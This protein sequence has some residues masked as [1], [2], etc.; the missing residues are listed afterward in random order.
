MAV[1]FTFCIISGI[2][3][4]IFTD[5]FHLLLLLA[6]CVVRVCVCI[7][8]GKRERESQSFLYYGCSSRFCLGVS[9]RFC[10]PQ[11]PFRMRMGGKRRR[12]SREKR[13]SILRGILHHFPPRFLSRA[14]EKINCWFSSSAAARPSHKIA[15]GGYGE[16]LRQSNSAYLFS[17]SPSKKSRP[18]PSHFLIFLWV[19][20]LIGQHISLPMAVTLDGAAHGTSLLAL[21]SIDQV[22]GEC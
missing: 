15:A 19:L 9:A 20:A 2:K 3:S 12:S 18:S 6:S 13:E 1:P 4:V 16:M 14:E 17:F 8:R 5:S 11:T 7:R 22:R 21:D 10:A